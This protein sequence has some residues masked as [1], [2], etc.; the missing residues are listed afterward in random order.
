M[1]LCDM[2]RA[3][4]DIE[5]GNFLKALKPTHHAPGDM[6]HKQLKSTTIYVQYSYIYTI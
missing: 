6:Q 2:E 3:L 4:N 1:G 5:G